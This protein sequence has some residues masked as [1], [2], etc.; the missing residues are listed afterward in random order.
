[1][2]KYFSNT[3]EIVNFIKFLLISCLLM[4]SDGLSAYNQYEKDSNLFHSRIMKRELQMETDDIAEINS[5]MMESRRLYSKFRI[6]I[7]LNI[8]SLLLIFF[9]MTYLHQNKGAFLN[10]H[11]LWG[12][13]PSITKF[14]SSF[15]QKKTN[16]PRTIIPK[17]NNQYKK[18]YTDLK[19]VM[20]KD[21]LYLNPNLIR[22]D[23]VALLHTNKNDLITA[24]KFQ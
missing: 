6:Y 23:V 22:D 24:W 3:T 15:K 20:E 17:R 12:H 16:F 13:N 9:Y 1:M 5:F 14:L 2:N 11:L 18:L 8:L 10:N 7:L 21:K 4:F 19:E